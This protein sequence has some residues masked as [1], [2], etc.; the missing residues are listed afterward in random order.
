MAPRPLSS[1][2]ARVRA[3]NLIPFARLSEA[4]AVYGVPVPVIA[5]RPETHDDA[6]T[7]L[8]PVAKRVDLEGFEPVPLRDK[9][10]PR[11]P[12]VDYFVIRLELVCFFPS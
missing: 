8:Q 9:S 12:T 3:N 4:H 5:Y 10:P 2:Y 11:G 7:K 6:Q 1:R